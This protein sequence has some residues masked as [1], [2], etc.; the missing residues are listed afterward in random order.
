[1][2]DATLKRCPSCSH[3]RYR[4]GHACMNCGYCGFLEFR[5]TERRRSR[6]T[7]MV[8]PTGAWDTRWGLAFIIAGGVLVLL[9][10][11]AFYLMI[12]LSRASAVS[13]APQKTTNS[14]PPRLSWTTRT[15]LMREKG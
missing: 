4:P 15:L 1:M 12:L 7:F 10:P 3:E 5:D 8:S 9:I 13:L 2:I 6:R 11:V 14:W